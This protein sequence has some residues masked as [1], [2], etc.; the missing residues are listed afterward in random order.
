MTKPARVYTDSKA[1]DTYRV[2]DCGAGWIVSSSA[3]W[4]VRVDI[5]NCA[6]PTDREIIYIAELIY[7]A[8]RDGDY[9]SR[10][11]V[12]RFKNKMKGKK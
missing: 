5:G 3:G 9:V 12:I 1:G 8:E 6:S 11:R 2:R 10:G 4:T 7:K